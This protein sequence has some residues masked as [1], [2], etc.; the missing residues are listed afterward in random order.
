MA[1]LFDKSNFAWYAV[2]AAARMVKFPTRLFVSHEMQ[3]YY[4]LSECRQFIA[5]N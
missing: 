4:T 2:L 1:Y 3:L 5:K